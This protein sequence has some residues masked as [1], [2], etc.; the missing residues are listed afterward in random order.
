[1]NLPRKKTVVIPISAG[2]DS[3]LCAYAA[4]SNGNKVLLIHFNFG[5]KSSLMELHYSKLT[6]A[7]LGVPIEIVDTSGLKHLQIGYVPINTLGLDELD[8]S[9]DPMPKAI[10][11]GFHTLM[12]TSAYFA[13]LRGADAILFGII[14]EQTEERPLLS[15]ALTTFSK[16]LAQINPQATRLKMVAP[17]IEMTKSEVVLAAV[18][19]QVPLENTWSCTEG[20]YDHCGKCFSC[21]E[22]KLAFAATKLHDP[23]IYGS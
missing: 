18:N 2:I 3:T 16:F 21:N 1:M 17:L 23:T 19:A 5:K 7:A 22:R 14:K 10:V 12:S 9:G 8:M 4:K 6:A 20:G 15:E 11:S 13:Q